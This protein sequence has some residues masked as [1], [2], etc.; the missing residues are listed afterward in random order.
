VPFLLVFLI[1]YVQ[2]IFTKLHQ[3]GF[4]KEDSI[5]QLFCEKCQ[6]FLA[7]RFVEGLIPV[8]SV[9][10]K[11]FVLSIPQENVHCAVF[12][13]LEEINAMAAKSC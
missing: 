12:Q 3:R 7:D 2:D 4:L 9:I 1:W 6:K 8:F 5:E 10:V 11:L 13:M